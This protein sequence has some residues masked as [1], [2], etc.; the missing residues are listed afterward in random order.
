MRLRTGIGAV[1]I[2]AVACAAPL[3]TATPS[4]AATS[5]AEVSVVHGIPNTPV[6][7]YVD[8]HRVLHDFTFGTVAG[9]LSLRP[10]THT[11]RIRPD[12][13]PDTSKPILSTTVKLRAGEDATLAADLTASGSPTINAFVD[14]T[15]TVA[16]GRARVIVRHVAAAPGVDVYAGSAKV[17][18]DLT[19]PH[20]AR[21][22]TSA[23]DVSVHVNVTGTATTV[24][25]PATLDLKSG[26]TT[27]VYAIGSVAGKTLTVAVQAY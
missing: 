21:L 14:P 20:Q 15:S 4:S 17:I 11:V 6:D 3:L 27:I 19:N 10:G 25:G 24:I 7:V 12:G 9:P 22:V 13:A 26:T 5:S 1:V 2:G 18:T 16:A 23:G 8:G